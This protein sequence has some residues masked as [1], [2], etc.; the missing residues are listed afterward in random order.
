MGWGWWIVMVPLGLLAVLLVGALLMGLLPGARRRYSAGW[1]SQRSAII[2]PASRAE[3]ETVRWRRRTAS[4]LAS[5][6]GLLIVGAL[7]FV[8]W[9]P[10]GDRDSFL[11]LGIWIV[12]I[13]LV[14]L[15]R[16]GAT[17]LGAAR[18]VRGPVRVAHSRAP[19][20]TDYVSRSGLVMSRITSTL[21]ICY[22]VAVLSAPLW[23][24]VQVRHSDP[25]SVWVLLAT[26][27]ICCVASEVLARKIVHQPV[28]SSDG[29]SLFWLDQLRGE[30]LGEICSLPASVGY[31][32]GMMVLT[33]SPSVANPPGLALWA[34]VTS[35]VLFLLV[36]SF[37]FGSQY[38]LSTRS[39]GPHQEAARDAALTAK[40]TV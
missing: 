4:Y 17:A 6:I 35:W 7:A 25:S 28:V 33:S 21:V 26:V 12:P 27:T 13:A 11:G 23:P 19:R 8:W 14:S 40:Q 31:F 39:S 10:Y 3:V 29:E 24:G 32:T 37:S 34:D 1:I 2:T 9:D 18:E 36:L 22:G 15:G 20:I 16:S 5:L 30:Q 38:L